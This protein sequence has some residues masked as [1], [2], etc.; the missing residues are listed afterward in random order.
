MEIKA[1]LRHIKNLSFEGLSLVVTMVQPVSAYTVGSCAVMSKMPLLVIQRVIS[2]AF[3]NP[4]CRIT[5]KKGY[6][7]PTGGH[8]QRAL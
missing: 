6:D 5:F 3:S 1:S 7:L 4:Y 2:R 8:E